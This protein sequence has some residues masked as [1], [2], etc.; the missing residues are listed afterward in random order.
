MNPAT[1]I[2]WAWRY[3][4]LSAETYDTLDDAVES[5]VILDLRGPSEQWA[6]YESYVNQADAA[7]QAQKWRAALG[8]ARVRLRPYGSFRT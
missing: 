4:V 7:N 5:S 6:T 1:V 8:P 2:R 3:H